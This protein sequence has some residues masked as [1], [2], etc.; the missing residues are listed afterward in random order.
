MTSFR[1]NPY[2]LAIY[3]KKQQQTTEDE[4]MKELHSFIE[5]EL[6]FSSLKG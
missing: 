6:F 1:K 2:T 3:S 4:N 5:L